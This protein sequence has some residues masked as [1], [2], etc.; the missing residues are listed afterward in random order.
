MVELIGGGGGVHKTGTKEALLYAL[1]KGG[2][3]QKIKIIQF[4]RNNGHD[5]VEITGKHLTQDEI[6]PRKE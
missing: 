5:Y 6:S 4:K 1:L 2:L 3:N